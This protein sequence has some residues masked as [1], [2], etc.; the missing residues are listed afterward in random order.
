MKSISLAVNSVRVKRAY[1]KEFQ[2]L[3]QFSDGANDLYDVLRALLE[4]CA[5]NE[6][7]SEE[8]SQVL[9]VTKLIHKG[10]QLEGLIDAGSFGSESQIRRLGEWNKIQYRKTVEDVDLH[11][12][13]FLFDIPKGR[14]RGYLLLQSSGADS[15]QTL[16]RKVL[17]NLFTVQFP[18]Y[19][20]Q[21][22]PLV[23]DELLRKLTGEAA[24]GTEI[25]FIR[26]K[27]PHDLTSVIGRGG[28][29]TSAGSIDLVMKFKEDGFLVRALERALRQKQG[30]LELEDLTFAYDNVKIKVKLGGKERTVDL[31]HPGKLRPTMEITDEVKFHAGNPTF[32]SLPA[33]AHD[34]LSD[35]KQRMEGSGNASE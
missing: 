12:F 21:F 31:G 6:R 26:H 9:Q 13:Y 20:M 15:V 7:K 27:A 25:R 24:K 1:I 14:E 19:R 16:L 22:D 10:R 29:D 30:I 17:H 34:L 33:A 35:M 3:D 5:S 28:T 2:P 23:P 8:S 4:A 11:P 32:A 18:G